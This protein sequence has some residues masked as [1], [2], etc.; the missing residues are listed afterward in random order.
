MWEKGIAY[1]QVAGFWFL[2]MRLVGRFFRGNVFGR[3]K[4]EASLTYFHQF[5]AGLQELQRDWQLCDKN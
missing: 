3:G 1:L 5:I 4:N 2:V